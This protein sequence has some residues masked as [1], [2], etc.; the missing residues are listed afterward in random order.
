MVLLKPLI[1][2]FDRLIDPFKDLLN[3]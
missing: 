1:S 2:G 3:D